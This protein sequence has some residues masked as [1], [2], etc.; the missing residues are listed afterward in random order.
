MLYDEFFTVEEIALRL[1]KS[2]E[3]VYQLIK[4]KKLKAYNV[5]LGEKPRY[6]IREQDYRRYLKTINK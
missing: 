4:S 1:K 5:G 3:H 2:K 6:I